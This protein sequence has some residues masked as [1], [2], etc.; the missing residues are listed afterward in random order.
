MTAELRKA[1]YSTLQNALRLLNLFSTDQ[2]ELSVTEIAAKLGLANSTAHRMLIS[3]ESEGLIMKEP[4]SSLYR[5][6]VSFLSLGNVITK[7]MKIYNYS[8]DILHFLQQSTGETASLMVVENDYSYIINTKESSYPIRYSAY[9]GQREPVYRSSTGLVILA[10][11]SAKVIHS[12]K[13]KAFIPVQEFQQKIDFIQLN[14]YYVSIDEF[15]DN[16][17]SITV[18]VRNGRGEVIA[19]LAIAGPSERILPKNIPS[20]TKTL[21][22]ASEQFTKS[23]KSGLM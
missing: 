2:P 17:T 4:K 13:E 10:F 20:F 18:P 23:L 7:N 9:T 1:K 12:I 22:A 15:Y 16:V 21:I 8:S 11:Q 14:G 19:A 6:G 3:L 5:L